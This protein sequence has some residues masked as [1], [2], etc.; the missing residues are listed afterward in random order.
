MDYK[1]Y[2]PLTVPAKC[3]ECH[4]K[5]IIK[6]YRALCDQCADKV[7]PVEVLEMPMEQIFHSKVAKLTKSAAAE[8]DGQEDHKSEGAESEGSGELKQV[9]EVKEESEEEVKEGETEET[10]SVPMD[11]VSILAAA[12]EAKIQ[13]EDK[14]VKRIVELTRCTKCA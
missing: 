14:V 12:S 13:E 5:N 10:K 8:E 3:N 6:A 11:K 9:E 4:K 1:K 2:K 7:I